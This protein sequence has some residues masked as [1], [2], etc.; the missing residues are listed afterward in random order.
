MQII[1]P[2]IPLHSGHTVESVDRLSV[3]PVA[4]IV[5]GSGI[6]TAFILLP[7]FLIGVASPSAVAAVSAVTAIPCLAVGSVSGRTLGAGSG[8]IIFKEILP[9]TIG[10]IITQMMFSIPTAIFTEAFLSFVG[11][12]IVLPQCSIGTL[13][14]EGFNNITILPYQILPPILV[15]ALLMLGFNF[16]GDGLREALAPKLEDM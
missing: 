1:P 5:D 2:G 14:E 12:G 11:V 13:I 7:G 10:P 6:F 15:L 4:D 9:N 16:I 8:H 3:H